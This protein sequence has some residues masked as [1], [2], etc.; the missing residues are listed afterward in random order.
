MTHRD[1]IL[2]KSDNISIMSTKTG[3][4]DWQVLDLLALSKD[5]DK[6]RLI[7]TK[8]IGIP[9]LGAIP[10]IF[11]YIVYVRISKKGKIKVPRYLRKHLGWYDVHPGDTIRVRPHQKGL[12]M[13]KLDDSFNGVIPQIP[14]S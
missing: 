14:Q 1:S 2:D 12:V 9:P 5:P 10:R 3:F 4:L 11:P 7:L 6:N 8:V 13:E